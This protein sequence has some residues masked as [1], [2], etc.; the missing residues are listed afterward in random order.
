M[1]VCIIRRWAREKIPVAEVRRLRARTLARSAT[2]TTHPARRR[3]L[4]AG[5]PRPQCTSNRRRFL[6]RWRGRLPGVRATVPLFSAGWQEL[7]A[8]LTPCRMRPYTLRRECPATLPGSLGGR[9][10]AQRPLPSLGP[11]SSGASRLRQTMRRR[12]EWIIPGAE[13]A[14]VQVRSVA[15]SATGIFSLAERLTPN[16]TMLIAAWF[17]FHSGWQPFPFETSG[18]NDYAARRCLT[19][20]SCASPSGSPG[21]AT[22]RLRRIRWWARCW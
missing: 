13:R 20:N 12:A 15:T 18:V 17:E 22:A 2:G 14:R 4:H 21:A 6:L 16:G 5:S 11:R 9:R 19:P 8:T 3:S 10:T 1:C 7:G